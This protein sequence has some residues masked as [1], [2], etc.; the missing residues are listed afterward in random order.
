[1]ECERYT[2]GWLTWD[3][4]TKLYCCISLTVTM[5][6]CQSQRPDRLA[7]AASLYWP[8]HLLPD[9]VGPA[10]L[11]YTTHFS[12]TNVSLESS[13]SGRQQAVPVLCTVASTT[14]GQ[15]RH[16]PGHTAIMLSLHSLRDQP[17]Q[18]QQG[19][20][21]VV[22]CCWSYLTLPGWPTVGEDVLVRPAGPPRLGLV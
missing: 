8:P 21:Q 22:S 7:A 10:G 11:P 1:M 12:A 3:Y 2:G 6:Q 5:C 9:N 16:W 13:S 15:Y 18:Q 19:W 17:Q 20:W 4:L 14:L